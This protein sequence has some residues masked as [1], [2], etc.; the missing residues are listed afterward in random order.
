MGQ[1]VIYGIVF[2]M[3]WLLAMGLGYKFMFG[4]KKDVEPSVQQD[5]ENPNEELVDQAIRR[6]ENIVAPKSSQVVK[7][8]GKVEFRVE[9]RG[10]SSISIQSAFVPIEMLDAVAGKLVNV[11]TLL[12]EETNRTDENLNVSSPLTAEEQSHSDAFA[13]MDME[14]GGEFDFDP[15]F[16]TQIE[17]DDEPVLT[18]VRT[19]EESNN[20][21]ELDTMDLDGLDDSPEIESRVEVS[22]EDDLEFG[23]TNEVDDVISDDLLSDENLVDFDDVSQDVWKPEAK[24]LKK[25]DS[26]K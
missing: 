16:E 22:V 2:G 11:D 4:K 26:A 10:V 14:A 15:E 3:L 24:K 18:E 19:D 20:E 13:E 23:N 5:E 9:E 12:K 21:S 1:E 25:P 8:E 17:L 7:S 6:E